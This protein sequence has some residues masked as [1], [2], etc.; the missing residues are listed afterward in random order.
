MPVCFM[1]LSRFLCSGS[2]FAERTVPSPEKRGYRNVA[3]PSLSAKRHTPIRKLFRTL[4]Y[5]ASYYFCLQSRGSPT[6]GNKAVWNPS[7]PFLFAISVGAWQEWV[8]EASVF[9]FEIC[10]HRRK[11][12]ALKNLTGALYADGVQSTLWVIREV[13][14]EIPEQRART[15]PG[16]EKGEG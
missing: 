12:T 14:M 10:R 6:S 11:C 1:V 3:R 15:G 5:V 9:G 13:K 16:S 7:Y 8:G 4:R 2:W